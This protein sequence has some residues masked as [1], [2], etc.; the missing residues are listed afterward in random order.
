VTS[1]T[2]PLPLIRLSLWLRGTRTGQALQRLAAALRPAG[3]FREWDGMEM[4]AGKRVAGDDP[5]LQ[6]ARDHFARNVDDLLARAGR[7][8]VPVVLS[9]VAVNVRDHAP[10][11]SLPEPAPAGFAEVRALLLR[12]ERPAARA[13][14]EALLQA[15]PAH[16]ESHFQRARLHE[17]D[18]EG[19]EA[20]AAYLNAWRH[21]ALRFRADEAINDRLRASA[22]AHAAHVELVDAAVAMGSDATAA[23]TAGFDFFFEHVHLTQAGNARLARLLAEAA[24]R[25]LWP[26]EAAGLRWP[27]DAT[28]AAALGFTVVGERAQHLAMA[29]LTARPPFTGQSTFGTDRARLAARIGQLGQRASD[30]A[31]QRAARAQVEQAVAR[32]P[33]DAALRTQAVHLALH[34]GDLRGAEAHLGMLT[35]LQPDSSELAGLEAFVLHRLGRTSAALERLR[36]AIEASPYYFANYTLLAALWTQSGDLAAARAWF[37][38]RAERWP[39]SR[40]VRAAQG[41]VRLRHGDPRGAEGA[42]RA[43]LAASP[44]DERALGPLAELLVQ[45]GRLDEAGALMERAFARNPFSYPNNERLVQLAEHRGDRVAQARYLEALI[46]SGPVDAAAF[47][48]LARLH[49]AAGR[50]DAALLAILEGRERFRLLGDD[51]AVRRLEAVLRTPGRN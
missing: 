25:R 4:F 36:T 6:R 27:D 5:A 33:R 7:Q 31:V 46:A 29:E 24:A 17:R 40:V 9:T 48:D 28:L 11:A 22:R 16:A 37:D 38:A 39:E 30:P 13:R 3:G 20:Q 51:A 44:D 35:T 8:G 21:D 14:L 2:P 10:F 43:V 47:L 15:N 34:E 45:Q 1:G 12:D 49:G 42:W 23:T 26:A 19:R 32:D 50:T 18:G 41:Q